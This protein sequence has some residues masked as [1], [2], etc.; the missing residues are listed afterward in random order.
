MK[1]EHFE[2]IGEK[3]VKNKK[4]ACELC[5][6]TFAKRNKLNAHEK[7]HLGVKVRENSCELCDAKFTR[8]DNLVRHIKTYHSN[9][10]GSKTMERLEFQCDICP[11]SFKQKR[12]LTA[13]KYIHESP[14]FECSRCAKPFFLMGKKN[15]HEKKCSQELKEANN[16]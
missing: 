5:P 10:V 2:E 4:F 1:H 9:G 12:I 13:H 3:I 16:S 8:K 14:R 7:T 11:Q 6:K 15:A